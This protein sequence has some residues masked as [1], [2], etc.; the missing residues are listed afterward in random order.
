MYC[1]SRQIRGPYKRK[2]IANHLHRHR[3]LKVIDTIISFW[4]I[5]LLGVF[6]GSYPRICRA[7]G[8]NQNFRKFR[9]SANWQPCS[10][11]RPSLSRFVGTSRTERNPGYEVANLVKP[12]ANGHNVVGCYMLRSFAHPVACCWES[13]RKVWNYVKTNSATLL[14]R[15][16]HD[17]Y[18]VYQNVHWKGTE[19]PDVSRSCWEL[20][21][22]F[23][24]SLY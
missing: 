16:F 20:L 9:L 12:R 10:P 8:T 7:K 2:K 14:G 19:K 15:Q 5:S 6:W 18:K 13:L 23:A 3:M 17:F 1:I 4:M 21:C 24:R 22:P 11:F